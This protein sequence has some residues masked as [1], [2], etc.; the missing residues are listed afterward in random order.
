M[1][2]PRLKVLF[3]L[4]ITAS[5]FSSC[6][7][8]DDSETDHTQHILQKIKERG[9]LIAIT[10]Y[11]AI[12]YFIY[13]GRTMGFEY[14]LV[15]KLGDHLGVDVEFIVEKD[16]N[17]MFELLDSAKGDL[18]AY[19]LTVTKERLQKVDFTNYHNTT[20]QVLVQRLPKRWRSMK[21]HEIDGYL[22]RN[23][24]DL[25]GK[26]IYVQAGSSYVDRLENLSDEIGGDINIIEASPDKTAEDLIEDVASGEIDFTIADENVAQLSQAYLPDIDISTPVSFPQKIAW[27]VHKNTAELIDTINTW[28]EAVRKTPEYYFLYDKY[29]KNR[30]AFRARMR[31]PYLSQTGGKI[32]EFDDMLKKYADTL[33]WDWRILASQI[34]QESQFDPNAKSWA[35]ATGLMQLMP[36]TAISYGAQDPND[37]TQSLSAG[38]NYLKWLDNFWKEFIEDDDERIKFVLASYNIGFGHIIDSRNL[39][40]KYGAD[41]N[42]W[43][44]NVEEY[45]LK[46]SESKY[47]NDSVVKNGYCRGIE[48][49]N[50]VKEILE[51]YEQY[52]QLVG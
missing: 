20:Q 45:L 27:A 28:I 34:Y 12:S 9:R 30:T 35:G 31:S 36:E 1:K 51:R 38:I 32:S 15:K 14:E 49:V 2:F 7:K 29:Y 10:G 8:N 23:Q 48:T 37:P 39:A 25:E 44:G 5:I 52:K 4:G 21:M 41:P 22:I 13:K 46:K 24:I 50:Y 11:N 17:K 19:N 42:K 33:G 6:G 18:I 16:L 43:F 40:L 26:T 3:L 47:F